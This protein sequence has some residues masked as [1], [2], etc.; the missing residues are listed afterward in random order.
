MFVNIVHV[1]L[2]ITRPSLS[3]I[4][5]AIISN[6][7]IY[8]R[9]RPLGKSNLRYKKIERTLRRR[10]NV[11]HPKKPNE[12]SDIINA[13]KEQINMVEYGLNLRKTK[14]LYINTIEHEEFSF[15]LFASLDIISLIEKHIPPEKRNYAVDGTFDVTP[16]KC[17]YQLL[18]I[19]IEYNKI[20]N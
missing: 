19:H 11:R 4:F 14:R 6:N 18:T 12:I 20:V 1:S 13:Y 2:F 17:F 16:M 3:Y 5:F 15:T 8:I 9:R 7:S 10:K